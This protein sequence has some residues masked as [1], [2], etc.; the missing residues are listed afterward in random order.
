MVSSAVAPTGYVMDLLRA[1]RYLLKTAGKMAPASA[2]HIAYTFGTMRVLN[3][4]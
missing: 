4:L 3:G 1:N 2:P